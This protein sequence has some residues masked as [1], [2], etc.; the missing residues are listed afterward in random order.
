MVHHKDNNKITKKPN[1]II[2]I[3]KVGKLISCTSLKSKKDYIRVKLQCIIKII[4]T[5][6]I[7]KYRVMIINN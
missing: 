7:I 3:I 1:Q 4:Q 6:A 2:K 5:L